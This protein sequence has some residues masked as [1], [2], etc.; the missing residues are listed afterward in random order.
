MPP[1]RFAILGFGHHAARRLVPAF[2]HTAEA[3][4]T[5][6]WRRNP[7]RAA[8]DARTHNLRAYATAEELCAS[9]NVDA[10][11]IT[12]PDAHHLADA[13]LAFAHGKAV[14]CEK[15]VAMNAAQAQRMLAASEA[16][17]CLFGVAQNFRFNRSI[18]W[19][20]SAIAEGRIGRPQIAQAQF[21]YIGTSSP[22]TWIADPALA[23]GGPIADVGVHCLDALRFL[24]ADEVASISVLAAQDAASGEVESYAALQLGMRSGAF[25]NVTVTARAPYRTAF[26]ITGS[27]GV[28]LCENG[29][30]VDRPV[31][32]TLR[33]AGELI[34]THTVSNAGAYSRMIDSFA[35]A[36]RG[37][38]TYSAGGADALINQRILDAAFRSWHSGL[39]EQ[40]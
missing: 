36:M 38:A 14:L 12:S 11:F 15:P 32:V 4:L 17:G 8:E 2:Q 35:L 39:R 37:E 31:E 13:E 30:T 5:G 18:E 24:L 16:A 3:T 29:L 20:R 33:K 26:E 19:V 7:E 1:I 6:F 10:V 21:A 25:A 40:L 23:T 28:L 9:P 34:E 22:R 27:E